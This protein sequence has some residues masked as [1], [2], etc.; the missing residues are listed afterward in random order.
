MEKIFV[1]ILVLSM[2]CSCTKSTVVQP[3]ILQKLPLS[4]QA[5]ESSKMPEH[6]PIFGLGNIVPASKGDTI[7]IDGF[8]IDEVSAGGIA[9]LRISYDELYKLSESNRRYLLSIVHIQEEE[10]QRADVIIARREAELQ[11][12]RDSWW[13]R[14]KV[15][16]GIGVG[17][18]LGVGVTIGAG[19]ILV[20]ME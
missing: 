12:I 1:F 3:E 7:P 13:E 4:E 10:M 16:V 17:V 11:E 6:L 18:V 5:E 15:F 9:D 20:E 19:K 2:L 14:N 8:I